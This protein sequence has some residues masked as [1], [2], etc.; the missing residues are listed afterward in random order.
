MNKDHWTVS[1]T[2]ETPEHP[3][4]VRST[5]IHGSFDTSEKAT[6]WG[7]N[8]LIGCFEVRFQDMNPY[9]KQPHE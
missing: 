5:T 7:Q 2:K 8:N 3:Y 4:S 1:Q 6:K 9:R